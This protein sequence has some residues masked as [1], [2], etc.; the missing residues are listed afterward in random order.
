[1]G[2]RFYSFIGDAP[3]T[4]ML[5]EQQMGPE[6]PF[7]AFSDSSWNDDMET[8]RSTG[9]YMIWYRGGIVDHSSNLPDPMAL[10]LAEAEYNEACLVFMVTNHLRMILCELQN[11]VEKDMKP[12][13]MYLDS[14]SAIAMGRSCKDTKH[15]RHIMRRFHY[16]RNEIAAGRL[17]TKWIGTEYQVVDLQIKQLPGPQFKTLINLTHVSVKDQR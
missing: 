17:E 16:M 5:V 9:G 8:G 2:I 7:Y 6:H 1:L 10:S 4:K 15:T 13:I 11:T 12:T 14:K 3:I